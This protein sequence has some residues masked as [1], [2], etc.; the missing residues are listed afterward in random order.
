MKYQPN[1]RFVLT[2]KGRKETGAWG[3]K[4][5]KPIPYVVVDK[6][7]NATAQEAIDTSKE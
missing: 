6:G 3:P 5:D 7:R 4:D 2:A 1:D